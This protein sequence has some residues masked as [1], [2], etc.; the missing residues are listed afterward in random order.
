[1]LKRER[2]FKYII[3]YASA[4]KF[5]MDTFVKTQNAEE[6]HKYRVEIKKIKAIVAFNKIKDKSVVAISLSVPANKAFQLAGE[7]RQFDIHLQIINKF[8][9]TEPVLNAR[10]NKLR[11]LKI[12]KL[13][14]FLVKQK[15][16]FTKSD[17]N[18]IKHLKN[19]DNDKIIKKIEHKIAEIKHILI[20]QYKKPEQLHEARKQIKK[21]LY[22]EQILPRRIRIKLNLNLEYLDTLQHSIGEWHDLFVTE[23]DLRARSLKK[24][25]S[26]MK[27]KNAQR[28]QLKILQQQ[29]KR[30]KKKVK[31]TN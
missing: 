22:V 31:L 8:N 27:L 10:I 2:Q 1:M 5:H 14:T 21:L 29:F 23:N 24:D 18:L 30:F 19:F 7:I 17:Q 20:Y 12:S 9:L 11:K 13:K 28:Y 15:E 26:L 16:I 6:L 25:V 3:K 4:A